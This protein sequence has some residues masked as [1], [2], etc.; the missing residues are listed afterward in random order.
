MT[1]SRQTFAT[2]P[3]CLVLLCSVILPQSLHALIIR[4]DT[5]TLDYENYGKNDLFNASS[6]V[7]KDGNAEFGS[8]SGSTAIDSRWGV[9]ARHTLRSVS[10]W[11]DDGNKARFRGTKWKGVYSQG[12]GGVLVNQVIHYDDDFTRFSNVI[13][14]AVVQT[15]AS[16]SAQRIA[17]LFA[18]YDE[19]GRVGSGVS[20]ANNRRDGADNDRKT[21]AQNTSNSNRWYEVRW[22][23]KNDIDV[24]TG[25]SFNGSPANAILQVDLDHPT[26]TSL[27]RFGGNTAI[28]LEYGSMNGDSGSPIYVDKNG[29]DAQIAGVLSGGSGNL[30]GDNVVYVRIRAFRNWITDTVLAN[31]DNRTLTLAPVP[32]QI[33]DS[34]AL[35]TFPAS[36]TGSEL[37]PQS[38]TYSLINPPAG[39]TIDPDTGVFSWTPPLTTPGGPQTITIQAKEDGVA[40]NTDTV[41]FFA[42]VNAGQITDFWSWNGIAPAWSKLEGSN[43][44]NLTGNFV[45]L[46]GDLHNSVY[47]QLPGTIPKDAWVTVEIKAADFHQTWTSG[48]ELEFGFFNG[49]PTPANADASFL[50]SSI[51]DV[52]NYN[53]DALENGLGNTGGNVLYSFTFQTTDDM[54]DP[55]FTLRK[56]FD[57]GRMAVDDVKISYA[58]GDSD[59]DGL[60]DNA[61]RLANTDPLNPDSDFDGYLDGYEALTLASDPADPSSPGGPNPLAVGINFI[62]QRGQEASVARTLPVNA[63]AG[64]PE[65]AQT[66]WNQTSALNAVSLSSGNLTDIATPNSGVLVDSQGNPTSIGL[67]FTMNNTWNINNESITPYGSLYAG[68]LDTNANNNASVTL[69]NIPYPEYDVYVYFGAGSSGATQT[70]TDGATIY[71]FSNAARY[72]DEPGAYVLTT[73]TGLNHPAANYARF[74]GKTSSSVTVT[75]LRGSANGGINA[76][77]IVPTGDPY[78]NWATQQ[79]LDLNGTGAP[80]ADAD[81]DGSSNL[82]EFVLLSNPTNPSDSPSPTMTF[83]TSV[84]EILFLKNGNATGYTTRVVWSADLQNWSESGITQSEQV[85]NANFTRVNATH[86]RSTTQPRFYRI[87]V[88]AP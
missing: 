61:E 15:N 17:P 59:N 31:P 16:C 84:S 7:Y 57:G 88:T 25:N 23:G 12:L 27:S 44:Y 26:N 34:G 4:H 73:D 72:I 14:I 60:D 21:E 22:G 66:N 87:E 56:N 41:S 52:P 1:H 85:L 53:G 51:A 54:T 82:L 83:G 47:Q 11:L 81:N 30:Y 5:P 20:G 13:D 48:G 18:G 68:Y 55:W 24:L 36:A 46:Q 9:H 76:I 2:L 42:T 71:S 69:S 38:V 65:V 78:E 43:S 64:A 77:Q 19:V 49:E 10:D 70:I 62:S 33:V 75:F 6:N 39:A 40:Q 3:I 58:F 80:L 8:L 28:D 74:S 79:G 35:L 63:Y 50:F 29:L 45:Y 86:P 37:P 67:S 32:D